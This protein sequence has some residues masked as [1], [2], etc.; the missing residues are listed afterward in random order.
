MKKSTLTIEV[1][2][3]LNDSKYGA[4]SEVPVTV[5]VRGTGS[6]GVAVSPRS[7]TIEEGESESYTMVLTAEPSDNV[8]ISISG[9]EDDVRIDKSSLRFTPSNWNTPKAVKVTLAQDDDA[10]DDREVT[11]QHEITSDDGTYDI[12]EPNSV[13]VNTQGR[14]R[15]KGVGF[16]NIPDCGCGV[17]RNVPGQAELQA[18]E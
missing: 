13:R 12:Y 8:T 1:S 11:L 18:D 4:V 9:A 10:R 3:S 16:T 6:K 5:L 7:L 2:E 14:R 15:G 17:E